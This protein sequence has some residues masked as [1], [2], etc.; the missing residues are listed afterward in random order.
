MS[1]MSKKGYM[2]AHK[3]VTALL[4]VEERTSLRA[5]AVQFGCPRVVP[6]AADILQRS[7]II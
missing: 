2:E 3:V 6:Q 7:G 4:G 5:L 1:G